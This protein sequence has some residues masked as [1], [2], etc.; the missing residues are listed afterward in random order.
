MDFLSKIGPDTPINA[1]AV[2]L[3]GNTDMEL[4]NRINYEVFKVL[5]HS[6]NTKNIHKIPL[7]L[8][9]SKTPLTKGMDVIQFK[10]RLGVITNLFFTYFISI[11]PFM[12]S[13]LVI[14][15]K[16]V[17]W[18]MNLLLVLFLRDFSQNVMHVK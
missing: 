2:N 1:F 6:S 13:V 14:L 7:M 8:A 5:S 11:L 4:C 12:R 16:Y 18:C 3:K 10:D 9:H 17:G 15:F